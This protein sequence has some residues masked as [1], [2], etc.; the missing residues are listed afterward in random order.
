MRL[1]TT[2]VLLASA[3]ISFLRISALFLYYHAPLEI[4]FHFTHVELPRLLNETDLLPPLPPV[5]NKRYDKDI[6]VNLSLIKQF[7]LR[8]CYGKE[9]YRFPGHFLIPDGVQVRFIKSDFDGLLP[10]P[11]PSN[12]SIWEGMKVAPEG[13]ND[14]NMENSIYYVSPVESPPHLLT[15]I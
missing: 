10:Q 7:G 12:V 14:V 11:F 9:W 8:I 6:D 3:I 4:S 13:L 15:M 1:L 5:R 2:N